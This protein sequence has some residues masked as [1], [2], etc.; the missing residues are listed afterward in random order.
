MRGC[1]SMRGRFQ[2]RRRL[3]RCGSVSWK[4]AGTAIRGRQPAC[5]ERAPGGALAACGTVAACRQRFIQLEHVDI[6]NETAVK[7]GEPSKVRNYNTA[8]T[9]CVLHYNVVCMTRGPGE[10][11]RGA[12]HAVRATRWRARHFFID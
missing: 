5:R 11:R 10:P 12:R 1:G 9:L 2:R 4:V 6:L 3:P 7:S 8:A